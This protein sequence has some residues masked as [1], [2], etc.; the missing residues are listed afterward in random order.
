LA[1]NYLAGWRLGGRSVRLFLIAHTLITITGIGINGVVFNLYLLRLG[2][3]PQ[4]V[5]LIQATGMAT[6]AL[7]SLP[8]GRLGMRWGCR[9]AMLRGLVLTSAGWA[10]CSQAELLALPWRSGWLLATY[11]LVSVGVALY[12]VNFAPFLMGH[13][14]LADRDQAFSATVALDPVGGFIGSLMGGLLPGL[15]AGL[16]GG[17]TSA[18]GPFRFSLLTSVLVLAPAIFLLRA[19]SDRRTGDPQPTTRD[20]E[21]AT[22]NP[23]PTARVAPGTLI[24]AAATCLAVWLAGRCTIDAF[25]NVYLDSALAVPTAQLGAL[26]AAGQ[27]VAAPAVL[28]MPFLVRRWGQTRL[29]TLGG[30]GAALGLALIA[31][32]PYW[33]TAGAG[34][35]V[36]AACFS[37]TNATLIVYTLEI[38]APGWRETMSGALNAAGGVGRATMAFFGGYAILSIG[39]RGLFLVGAACMAAGSLLFWVYFHRRHARLGRHGPA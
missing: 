32:A 2:Y 5:G 33:S 10:L 35:M 4:F 29:I 13:T 38:V 34:L 36:I 24:A 3:G 22:R 14:A 21:P 26:R 23:E 16:L 7:L 15:Y 39:Y 9:R 1:S 18:P 25:F 12:Y 30:L 20:P 17:A 8:A 27:L 37:T 19:T 28:S 11:A 31:L 6:W